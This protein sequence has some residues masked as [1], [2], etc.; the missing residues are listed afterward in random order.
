MAFD[1]PGTRDSSTYA[2][3]KRERHLITEG[4]VCLSIG[5]KSP[6]DLWRDLLHA[7]AKATQT[8]PNGFA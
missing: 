3:E 1:F 4:L 6:D 8:I 5:L 7:L 2:R